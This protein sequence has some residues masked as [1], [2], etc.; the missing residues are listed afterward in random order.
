MSIIE[1]QSLLY[2]RKISLKIYHFY[3]I[4]IIAQNSVKNNPELYTFLFY[5]YQCNHWIILL[6]N[7]NICSRK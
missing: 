2:K 3:K 6:H 7:I 5:L 1:Y 4:K